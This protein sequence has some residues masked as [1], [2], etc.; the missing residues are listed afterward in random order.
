MLSL[1]A[2][3]F[4]QWTENFDSQGFGAPPAGWAVINNGD[5]NDWQIYGFGSA[6]SGNNVAI[7]S[8]TPTQAHDDYLITKAIN[9]Q[10]G[11]SDRISFYV[12]SMLIGGESRQENYEVLLSNTNQTAPAFTKV[13]QTTEKAPD[14]WIKKTFS[15]TPYA[16]QTVYI[17][18]HATD[19]DQG[20]LLADT[21]VVDTEPFLS[22]S[23]TVIQNDKAGIYPNPFNEVLNISNVRNV[24]KISVTDAS[25][26]LIKTIEK[27]G[28]SIPLQDLEPGLYFIT[29]QMKNGSEQM[30]KIV[31]K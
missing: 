27:P 30:V 22:V 21:F 16:G 25:G 5:P 29:L 9:V 26:K 23:E 11:I 8:A 3:S 13:L 20:R 7:I 31:K 28:S 2:L 6:Q 15:L 10:A 24:K 17:A 14:N 19:I 12:R 18:I 4:A 1:P